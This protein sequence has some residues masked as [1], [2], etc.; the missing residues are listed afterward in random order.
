MGGSSSKADPWEKANQKCEKFGKGAF[1]EC[2]VDGKIRC[3][4]GYLGSEIKCDKKKILAAEIA[5]ENAMQRKHRKHRHRAENSVWEAEI[6]LQ[7][8]TE[9]SNAKSEKSQ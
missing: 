8:L 7:Y 9:G 2:D 1:R 3:E 4:K 5:A 6:K